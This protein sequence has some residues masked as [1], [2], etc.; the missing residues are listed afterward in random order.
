[1]EYFLQDFFT[2]LVDLHIVFELSH[3]NLKYL[4]LF[5]DF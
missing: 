3:F 2:T 1:M 4:F 5:I